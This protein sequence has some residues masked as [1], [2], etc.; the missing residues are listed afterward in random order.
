MK[1][2]SNFNIVIIHFTSLMCIFFFSQHIV[3]FTKFILSYVIPDVPYVVKEQ[4][5]REKY[6][7]QMLLHETN[8]KLVNK[9]L[10]SALDE[11]MSE[12][13]GQEEHEFWHKHFLKTKEDSFSFLYRFL[14]GF[15]CI[16]KITAIPSHRVNYS[17]AWKT[18][19]YFWSFKSKKEKNTHL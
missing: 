12:A 16:H 1:T 19:S 15:C 14:Q 17:A 18:T 3:Y 2:S 10:K 13:K 11:Q 9:R 6:L 5:K 4:I 7:T 8:L